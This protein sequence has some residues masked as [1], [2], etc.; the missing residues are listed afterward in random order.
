MTVHFSKKYRNKGGIGMVKIS[1]AELEVMKVIWERQQVTSTE[2]IK[3]LTDVTW[4]FNTI[5]TLIKRLFVKGA[6]EIVKKEGKTYT[7]KASI[8][9][10]IYKAEV[11]RKWLKK[12]YHSSISELVLQY[13]KQE[14]ISVEEMRSLNEKIDGIIMEK[15]RKNQKKRSMIAFL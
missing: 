10:D 1:D 15:Q 13:C 9:E 8:E 11:L 7:Y 14:D 12:M 6:I 4:N 2:I 5:R 3:A